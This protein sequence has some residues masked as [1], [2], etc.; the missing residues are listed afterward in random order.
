VE[1]I[2]RR[3]PA[4][5]GEYAAIHEAIVDDPDFQAITPAAKC[6][7]YT[8]KL[9]LGASGIGLLRA[10]R[11]VLETVTRI[12]RPELYSAL[13]ELIDGKWLI[14]QGDVLWL[15]N[16]LRHNPN[17]TLTN[18]NH[19]KAIVK[20]LAGLP[21]LEIVNAFA[22]YYGFAAPFSNLPVA[23]DTQWYPNGIPDQ[24]VGSRSKEVGGTTTTAPASPA[25]DVENPT[26]RVDERPAFTR[27]ELW[28]LATDRLGLGKL[29]NHEHAANGRILN[30]WLYSSAKRDPI[31]IA[32]AIEGAA[33]MRDRDLIG[34]D[35]A[36]PGKPMTLK[37]LNG[38]MTLADQGDGKA[39]R[40][41][42]DVA[43]EHRRR[44]DD[45]RSP[46]PANRIKSN[47]MKR[48]VVGNTLPPEAA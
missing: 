45:A 36:K 43:V 19:R 18:D 3:G 9:M 20:H 14:V 27:S 48:A 5:R 21:R 30:D 39:V 34:W 22:T 25:A 4:L 23:W 12:K 24:E 31:E 15:R 1:G 47:A 16:G 32:C 7:W 37:A 42:Y 40:S 8:L 17:L 46:T 41:L 2:D 11:E 38:P 6:C 33:D 29:P 26:G 13:N 28:Q 44:M 10:S 35:S